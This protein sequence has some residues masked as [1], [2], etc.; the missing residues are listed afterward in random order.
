MSKLSYTETIEI[1]D[2]RQRKFEEPSQK[3]VEDMLDNAEAQVDE[4]RE[5]EEEK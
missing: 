1:I 3:E 4:E 2:K 5:R